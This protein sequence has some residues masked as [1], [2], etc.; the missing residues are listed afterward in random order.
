MTKSPSSS[1]W[2]RVR[3][4]HANHSFAKA[5]TMFDDGRFL[6]SV[7][8]EARAAGLQPARG[9]SGSDAARRD[10]APPLLRKFT[11]QAISK[12]PVEAPLTEGADG[13]GGVRIFPPNLHESLGSYSDC[14]QTMPRTQSMAE[15]EIAAE[16]SWSRRMAS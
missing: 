2:Q 12:D 11:S 14:F 3:A 8:L 10:D 5:K 1:S 13:G 16:S 9:R 6:R 15:Q 4:A 7:V